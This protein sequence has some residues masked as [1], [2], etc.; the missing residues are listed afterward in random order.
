MRST[1]GNA[2]KP[3]NFQNARHHPSFPSYVN[4]SVGMSFTSDSLPMASSTYCTAGYD[5]SITQVIWTLI[6]SLI[7]RPIPP[8]ELKGRIRL[9]RALHSM[10]MKTSNVQPISA[11]YSLSSFWQSFSYPVS[12]SYRC[13]HNSHCTLP[14]NILKQVPSSSWLVI[15]RLR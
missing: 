6:W 2:T 9:P 15:H 10:V 13:K 11:I 5:H 3:F 1:S 4:Y 8:G 14:S 7:Q 12:N